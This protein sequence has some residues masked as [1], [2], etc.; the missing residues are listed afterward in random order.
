MYYGGHFKRGSFMLTVSFTQDIEFGRT[1]VHLS[2]VD[3][4]IFWQWDIAG[5]FKPAALPTA[6]FAALAAL[7]YA[8]HSKQDL[9]IKGAVSKMLLIH[10]EET[11]M[12]WHQWCPE[13]F[14]RLR[15]SC[16]SIAGA[17]SNVTH[18]KAVIAF[19]GGVDSTYA[20]AV[21][22]D[23]ASPLLDRHGR[24]DIGLAVFVLGFDYKLTDTKGYNAL[25][26]N[27]E[28]ICGRYDVP[29]MEVRTNYRDVLTPRGLDWDYF[30]TLATSAVLHQMSGHF[31][32]GVLA[33]DQTYPDDMFIMP[34]AANSS[35]NQML[36]SD[37]FCLRTHG[38]DTLRGQ[39]VKFLADCN[40]ADLVNVCWKGPRTGTNCGKCEKCIRT[41]L[42]MESYA[43]DP[44]VAFGSRLTVAKIFTVL[45]KKQISRHFI[46][47]IVRDWQ[48]GALAL[49][50]AARVNL[51]LSPFVPVTLVKQVMRIRRMLVRSGG[52]ISIRRTVL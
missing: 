28:I 52:E 35:S 25:F 31:R 10:L 14:P 18:D 32:H 19:S 1:E 8:L 20:L 15:I 45:F 43:I 13:K 7:P 47:L 41:M 26:K 11:V 30:H 50:T 21:N 5:A 6:D 9:H 4:P 39:K 36:K 2:G 40:L 22:M 48:N 37:I 17:P 27:N 51:M 49:K 44:T 16:D 23:E 3:T 33:A 34:S 46:K 24:A 29:L 12:L 38:I 42:M